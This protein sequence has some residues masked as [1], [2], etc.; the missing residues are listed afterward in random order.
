MKILNSFSVI[1]IL[2]SVVLVSCNREKEGCIDKFASNYDAS[3][4]VDDGSC[5]FDNPVRGCTNPLSS[6]FNPDA[7]VDDGSCVVLGCTNPLADNYN[8]QAT[9]DDSSCVIAGCTNP[10]SENYNPLA[11]LDDGSCIDSREKFSGNWEITNDC[12]FQLNLAASTTITFDENTNDTVLLDPFVTGSGSPTVAVVK[13]SS[14]EI[15]EQDI[16]GFIT[17]SGDGTINNEQDQIDIE[18]SYSSFLG[19]STCS[20]TLVKQ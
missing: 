20:A 4:N 19:T 14:I 18:L 11:N 13:G 10:N 15:L 16:F 8:P 9:I 12:G 1:T 2:F 6:N 17:Y 5:V 7:T 3:A